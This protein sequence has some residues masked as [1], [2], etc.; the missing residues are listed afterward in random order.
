MIKYLLFVL[1]IMLSAIVCAQST[2]R[3]VVASA[4]GSYLDNINNFAMDYTIGEPAITTISNASVTLNQGFQQPF[5]LLWVSVNET[6]ENPS[7][8]IIFPNPLVN[9]LNIHIEK[10]EAGTYSLMLFDMLGQLISNKIVPAVDNMPLNTSID[11]IE[12]ATGNYFI[13]IQDGNKK[14]QTFKVIK[15]NQKK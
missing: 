1:V 11:F 14:G 12:C 6:N 9:Q 15:I 7:E 5:K 8:I 13:R 4:G 2:E 10:P 3:Q